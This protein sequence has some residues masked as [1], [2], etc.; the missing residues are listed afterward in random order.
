MRCGRMR[1]T[2]R[3]FCE[4]KTLRCLE[5]SNFGALE[6]GAVFP[7]CRALRTR[8]TCG[9]MTKKKIA[10]IGKELTDDGA[11]LCDLDRILL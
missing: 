3:G 4:A 5:S 10:L 11:I 1:R 7:R 2:Q 6:H 9:S 8:N